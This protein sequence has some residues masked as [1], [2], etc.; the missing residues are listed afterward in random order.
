MIADHAALAIRLRARWCCG[1]R[2][3]PL[4]ARAEA[5]AH[6]AFRDARLSSLDACQNAQKGPSRH[7]AAGD[8]GA[9]HAAMP[10]TVECARDQ[11]RA[12][13]GG[14]GGRH[15]PTRAP[16]AA[17]RT[18]RIGQA[19]R[20]ATTD[21]GGNCTTETTECTRGHAG[22]HGG[23]PATE[24]E[25]PRCGPP[26]SPARRSRT[27]LADRREDRQNSRSTL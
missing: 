5:D 3:A 11:L 9:S 13:L 12:P 24:S 17:A 2:T 22:D 14:R 21:Y 1:R 16:T 20:G 6:L 27:R 18:R 10:E 25:I 15:T 7:A 8:H 4:A 26:V 23:H 19:P